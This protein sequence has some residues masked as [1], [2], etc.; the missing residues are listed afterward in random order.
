MSILD[1][2][3]RPSESERVKSAKQS[4]EL[5]KGLILDNE[6]IIDMS[7]HAE[8]VDPITKQKLERTYK[9]T[10]KLLSLDLLNKMSKDKRVKNVFFTY[11]LKPFVT[12]VDG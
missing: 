6:K 12:K 2:F 4:E 8:Y 10:V 3:L 7:D 1:S 5:I 11:I 9:F